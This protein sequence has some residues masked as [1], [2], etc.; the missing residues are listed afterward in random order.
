MSKKRLHFDGLEMVFGY[1]DMEG[2][3][4]PNHI[5]IPDSILEVIR[6]MTWEELGFPPEYSATLERDL[7]K[8]SQIDRK[9]KD[10]YCLK[11]ED[12][13]NQTKEMLR[14]YPL[15]LDFTLTNSFPGKEYITSR[16]LFWVCL[17]WAKLLQTRDILL[18]QRLP[19]EGTFELNGRVLLDWA[20]VDEEYRA[21]HEKGMMALTNCAKVHSRHEPDRTIENLGVNVGAITLP[22]IKQVE[23]HPGL[24]WILNMKTKGLDKHDASEQ[25]KCRKRASYQTSFDRWNAI[26]S[27]TLQ[28]N[29]N[30]PIHVEDVFPESI[31]HASLWY[32][33][34]NGKLEQFKLSAIR[35]FIGRK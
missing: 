3:T 19:K 22:T 7:Q 33:S 2:E 21:S 25:K 1:P 16:E 30:S 12:L 26:V 34:K 14:R 24:R 4:C 17:V 31:L 11:M 23:E 29:K 5:L 9:G 28:Y 13:L 15:D 27:E 10:L 18:H 8:E 35:H 20:K 6:K 32:L